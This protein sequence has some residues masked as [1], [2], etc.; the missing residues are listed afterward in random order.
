MD[1]VRVHAPHDQAGE[2]VG[3]GRRRARRDGRSRARARRRVAAPQQV[4]REVSRHRRRRRIAD[5]AGYARSASAPA[6]S[7]TNRHRSRRRVRRS[8]DTR[9][10]DA[11]AQPADVR[12]ERVIGGL[13]QRCRSRARARDRHPTTRS[14]GRRPSAPSAR[15]GA[16]PRRR[17]TRSAC[18]RG[19]RCRGRRREHRAS[20]AALAAAA[21]GSPAPPSCQNVPDRSRRRPM[22]RIFSI[23]S[24]VNCT[25]L[26]RAI[27]SLVRSFCFLSRAIASRSVGVRALRRSSCWSSASRRRCSAVSQREAPASRPQNSCSWS[28]VLRCCGT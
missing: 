27:R 2:R 7:S 10:G 15:A 24:G 23:C 19:E 22:A 6:A 16:H 11:P 8:R 14:S 28:P 1:R 25:Q 9:P 3:D 12:V 5:V 26:R 21:H 20:A 18:R 13:A 17:R 4:R